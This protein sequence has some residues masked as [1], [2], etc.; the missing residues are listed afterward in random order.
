MLVQLAIQ[1]S[2]YYRKVYEQ[3][4]KIAEVKE[5]N[6][7]TFMSVINHNVYYFMAQANH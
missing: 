2:D 5:I 3:A 4:L 7:K 1:T 6:L